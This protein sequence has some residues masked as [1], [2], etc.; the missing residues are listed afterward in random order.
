MGSVVA[1]GVWGSSY[2]TASLQYRAL[3]GGARLGCAVGRGMDAVEYDTR[4]QSW[5]LDYMQRCRRGRALVAVLH[6]SPFQVYNF[7]DL[8]SSAATTRHFQPCSLRALSS[9]EVVGDRFKELYPLSR[10]STNGVTALLWHLHRGRVH[11]QSPQQLYD[12]LITWD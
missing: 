7:N 4:A 11:Q 1:A 5:I 6:R 12:A 2:W 9:L 10:N 8:S 3:R